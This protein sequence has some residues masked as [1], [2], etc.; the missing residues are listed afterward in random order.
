[1]RR[2]ARASRTSVPSSPGGARRSRRS[3]LRSLGKLLPNVVPG[4]QWPYAALGS[5]LAA[6]GAAA[7]VL[8]WWRYARVDAALRGAEEVA[9]PRGLAGALAAAIAV[10]GAVAVVMILI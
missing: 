7:A 3:G 1:M 4:T 6:I 2:G 8:G 9:L 10:V 5:F